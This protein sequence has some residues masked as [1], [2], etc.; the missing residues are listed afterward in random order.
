MC[1]YGVSPTGLARRYHTRGIAH[2]SIIHMHTP[3][4][5]TGAELGQG[6]PQPVE[7]A[8]VLRPG[9]PAQQTAHVSQT[10]QQT[11]NFAASTKAP[12]FELPKLAGTNVVLRP[13][14]DAYQQSLDDHLQGQARQQSRQ[15]ASAAE[16]L[17]KPQPTYYGTC[18]Q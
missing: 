16:N 12:I 13:P 14:I 10:E 6:N 17:Q 9:S 5:D 11:Q 3:G 7:E 1:A 2:T 8:H 4:A 18:P 15:F